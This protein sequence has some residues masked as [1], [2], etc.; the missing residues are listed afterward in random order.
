VTS[1]MD[2]H[3]LHM[4]TNPMVFYVLLVSHTNGISFLIQVLTS[5]GKI[6]LKGG[7]GA[8]GSAVDLCKC[9]SC[10]CIMML[11]SLGRC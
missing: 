1:G 11:D 9:P 4:E 3:A 6:L 8:V 5:N 10:K 2:Y 7:K